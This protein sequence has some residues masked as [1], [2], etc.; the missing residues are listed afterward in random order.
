MGSDARPSPLTVTML[1]PTITFALFFLLVFVASWALMPRFRLWKWFMIVASLVFYGWWDVRFVALL[2][3]SALVNQGLRGADRPRAHRAGAPRAGW[4][5]ALV[6]NLGLLGVF[7]YYNFFVASL[8]DAAGRRALRAHVPAARAGALPVGLSFLTFRVISYDVDLYRGELEPATAPDFFVYVTFFPY[9]MAGPIARAAEFLPQLRGPRDP[10][11]IDAGRAFFL[12]YAGLLKKMLLADYLA[13]QLVSGVFTTPDQYTSLETLAAIFGYSVQI[14]CDFSAYSDIAIG[15]VAAA[16]L[17]AARQL[18]R[19]LH[20]AHPAGLLA[21]LA[22]DALE[23]AAR[24]PLHPA[25]RQ[26]QGR[27]SHVRQHPRDDAARQ[28]SGTGPPGRS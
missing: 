20:G 19:P 26:P 14:Y 3:A 15:I 22:H 28:D 18:R 5:S 4:S 9:L 7:K 21:P 2:A 23:L 12:I 16:R 8:S 25:G 17:R 24:L 13:T 1:F 11:S 10:R 27:A 6:F